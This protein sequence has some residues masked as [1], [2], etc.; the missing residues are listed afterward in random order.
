MIE[1]PRIDSILPDIFTVTRPIIQGTSALL[2]S[3]NLLHLDNASMFPIVEASSKIVP[4]TR[5]DPHT[6]MK[7]YA[8]LGGYS[9]LGA[10][11][12]TDPQD[13]PKLLW[14]HCEDFPIW[15]GTVKFSDT[16]SDLLKVFDATKLGDAAVEGS[17]DFPA[18]VTLQ[19]ILLL[20]RSNTIKSTLRVSEIGSEMV[21]ISP[22]SAI[23]D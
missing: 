20:H 13:Y 23:M 14:R 8:S 5:L 19:E 18:L 21:T 7:M 22:D 11:L 1:S 9:V 2:V 15:R 16:L 10:I 6:G 3:A 17:R 12:R 4:L